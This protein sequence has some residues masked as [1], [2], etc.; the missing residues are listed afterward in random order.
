MKKIQKDQVLGVIGLL[1]AAFFT[2]QSLILPK[3]M[4]EGDPGLAMFPLLGCVLIAV[5][6][7]ILILRPE[8]GEEQGPFLSGNQWIS[9]AILFGIYILD[10]LLLYLFGFMVATYSIL[11]IVT[12]MFA[13]VS[14][15]NKSWKACIIKGI[16]YAAIG[17]TLLYLI[18]IVALDAQMPRGEVWKILK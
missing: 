12:V 4:F 16:I 3:P 9:A 17:G 2:W 7:I 6:G 13:R 18:Y 10:C 15:E 5:C 11:F 8:K 14:S 1:V